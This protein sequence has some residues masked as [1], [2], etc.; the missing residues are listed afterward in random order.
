MNR[1]RVLIITY[2]WPPS[3]GSGVQRW[4]KFAKFLRE[5]GWAPIVYTPE[6]HEIPA[7]DLSLG[8]ELPDDLTVIKKHIFEPYS[9]YKKFT[10]QNKD[11]KIG[12]AFI[13]DQETP[14][15]AEKISRWI[16]GNLFIPDPRVLW[17]KPSVRFLSDYLKENPVDAIAT[18]GPPHSM[19]L[20]GF[21]LRQKLGIPWLADFRDPWTE[22]E[23]YHE[24]MPSRWAD[25]KHHRL[26]RTVVKQADEV[27]TIGKS[28][29]ESYETMYDRNVHIVTNG[30]DEEDFDDTLVKP[31]DQFTISYIGTMAR[32]QNPL[33]LWKVLSDMVKEK[34]AF[35][36]AL[37]IQLIGKT[38]LAVIESLKKNN[39]IPYLEEVGYIPHDQVTKYQRRA[40][41]L[42]II[43]KNVS[44]SGY[45]LP[46]KF[47]EYMAAKRPIL[48]I[49][50]PDGDMGDVI[51]ECNAGAI[52]DFG[53]YE[54]TKK[55]MTD[56]YQKYQKGQ[57][58][59]MSKGIEQYSR[60]NLT[61][62]IAEIMD[63]MTAKSPQII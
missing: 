22:I 15:F 6:N 3:G 12:A 39:L 57:L 2:Y 7:V 1:K 62:K 18:T 13:S 25:K 38:D 44:I 16:R 40:Q 50:P 51:R 55:I 14:K 58:N 48:C 54:S 56:F 37:K 30:Y 19:H 28:M 36:D 53:D 59:A 21:H 29:A 24:F 34:A 17:V 27:T 43:S 8:K 26:E 61:K 32:S 41:V 5:F 49:G 63:L 10:G 23:F 20:I 11:S 60:K 31:D 46:A 35:R 52:A 4:V 9:F 42:L 33:A 47:F 45:F